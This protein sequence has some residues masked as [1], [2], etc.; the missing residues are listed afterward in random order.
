MWPLDARVREDLRR[1]GRRQAERGV[2]LF[3]FGSVARTWP[4]AARGSDLDIGYEL[5]ACDP[6]I[7]AQLRRELEHQVEELGTI[8][9]IDLIDFSSV[10]LTFR[11]EA[12]KRIVELVDERVA[13][14]TD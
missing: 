10:A 1:L 6:T 3:L 5:P 8:R 14:T 13:T 4:L 11:T 12:M 9:P 7:A 2:R